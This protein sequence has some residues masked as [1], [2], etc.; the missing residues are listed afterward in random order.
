MDRHTKLLLTIIAAALVWIGVKDIAIVS[1]ALAASGVIE[2]RVVEI[3]FS[4]Y[5]PVPV[6]VKGEIRCE[7]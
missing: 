3:D 1:D 4:R 5:R 7:K 6:Q 2:V